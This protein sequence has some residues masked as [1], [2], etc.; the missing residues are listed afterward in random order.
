MVGDI[1]ERV[2]TPQE[3][4]QL[5]ATWEQHPLNPAVQ[6]RQ[7]QQAA[8]QAKYQALRTK[9]GLTEQELNDLVGLS[10]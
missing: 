5:L 9:L 6:H 4:D 8:R 3:A 10:R 1:E 2:V 7:T